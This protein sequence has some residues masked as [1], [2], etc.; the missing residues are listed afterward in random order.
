[1]LFVLHQ[2]GFIEVSAIRVGEF[3]PER[4]A[5]LARTESHY[6]VVLR[7]RSL[8]RERGRENYTATMWLHETITAIQNKKDEDGLLDWILDEIHSRRRLNKT[9]PTPIF[10]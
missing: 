3:V 2:V 4:G 8:E 5:P 10:F 7:H 6:V 1:M 9:Q